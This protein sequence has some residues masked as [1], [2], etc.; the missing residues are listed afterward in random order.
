MSPYEL[1]NDERNTI[2]AENP[3]VCKGCGSNDPWHK[4]EE[5]KQ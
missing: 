4:C 1:D 5:I 3:F 2:Y